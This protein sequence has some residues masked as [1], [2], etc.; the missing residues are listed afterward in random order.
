MSHECDD[1]GEAF[2]T[3]SRLR[4]HDCSTDAS[5]EGSNLTQ[6]N[7]RN[8]EHI[9]ERSDEEELGELDG[10]LATIHDGDATALHQAMATYETQLASAHDS[11]NTDR[12][13]SISKAYRVE[14]ITALD[15]ATQ[16]EGFAFL[17]EFLDAYHPETADGFPHVTTVLQNVSSRYMI[18]T[19]LSDG[20]E[21]V[22]VPILGFFSSILGRVKRDG[23]DFI[24]EG[25]HPYGWGIGHP[26]HSVADDIFDHAATD[27]FV[28]N[29][30]LEH[31]FYAD[32]HLAIDLL[33]R[34][35]RDDSI[36]HTITQPRGEV[37]ETRYLLDAPAG[38]VSEFDPVI[39]R[40]W[41][42][43]EELDY[44]FELDDGVEQRIRHLVAE[45][46]IDDDLPSD[47]EI[48]DL[49]L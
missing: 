8:H 30:M 15:D 10:L 33:E 2:E 6:T 16:T 1:C 35:A 38:A 22:P 47:W 44:E 20:I 21:A 13:R 46:G 3:L 49:T 32:Q 26:D 18:R 23:Y 12:Y 19:R 24:N 9:G 7:E 17:A 27:I 5:L 36:Q 43:Q 42:W 48:A 39:P 45:H 29:P 40:Y 37:S 11:G 28:V 34:I 25:L 31:A 41:E 4:L 14:L